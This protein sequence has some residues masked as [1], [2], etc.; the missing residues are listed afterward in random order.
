MKTTAFKDAEALAA[1]RGLDMSKSKGSI[2][3]TWMNAGIASGALSKEIMNLKEQPGKDILAHGG[4]S[5]AQS[6]AS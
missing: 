3:P 2:S 1:L 5:F 4:A 6:L